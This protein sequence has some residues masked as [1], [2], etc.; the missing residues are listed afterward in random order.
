MV[1][2]IKKGLI[3]LVVTKDLSRLG[4][5]YSQI[6]YY[7]DEFFPI[8]N[9]RYIAINDNIDTQNDN[10]MVGYKALISDTYSRDISKKVKTAFFT[11]QLKGIYMGTSAPFGY[12]KD[13]QNH[14]H[15]LIDD[16]SSNV[17]KQIFQEYLNGNSLTKIANKLMMEQVPTPSEYSKV[18][19]TPKIAGAWNTKTLRSILK[20]EVYIGHTVQHK[21]QCI[22]YK[23]RKQKAVEKNQ[24]IKVENTHEP[25]IDKITYDNVQEILKKRSYYPA[26]R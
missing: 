20:N 17:I 22:N 2:D 18:K 3:N 24:W 13:V 11:R 25:I 14:G 7:V 15:L 19:N 1:E 9:V 21:K 10:E 12:K 16:Y 8:H 23:V 4:R 26:K 5:N 6:G